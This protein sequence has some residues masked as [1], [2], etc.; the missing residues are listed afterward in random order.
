MFLLYFAIF[1]IAI[2]VFAP[3][4]EE[5][6]FRGFFSQYFFKK[7][8]KWLKLL[9]SSSIFAL[10][11][12]MRPVEFVVYFGLG[13]I[14]YLAYARRNNIVDSIIVHLLNNGL[15]VIVSVVNYLILILT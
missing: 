12:I 8:Q 13:A 5:L 1:H 4:M 11:H 2:G 14:F 7:Q 10:L 9:V 15:L 6:V 3:I